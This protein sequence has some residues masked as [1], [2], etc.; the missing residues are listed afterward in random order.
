MTGRDI[1]QQDTLPIAV[2]SNDYRALK[3]DP[4]SGRFREEVELCTAHGKDH[5]PPHIWYLGGCFALPPQQPR[6]LN[7]RPAVAPTFRLVRVQLDTGEIVNGVL[8]P[9][10]FGDWR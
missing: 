3:D 1:R 2:H 7:P 10:R 6:H 5:D 4:T 9:A 8:L